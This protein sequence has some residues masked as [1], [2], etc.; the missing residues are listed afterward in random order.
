MLSIPEK[1][2]RAAKAYL[3]MGPE[4]IAHTELR[5]SGQRHSLLLYAAPPFFLGLFVEVRTAMKKLLLAAAGLT[6][7]AGLG[8]LWAPDHGCAQGP[9]GKAEAI[10]VP[11]GAGGTGPAVPANSA[12]A[13]QT[14]FESTAP[15]PDQK[16]L[17]TSPGLPA[18]PQPGH[19]AKDATEH[20]HSLREYLTQN[21]DDVDMNQD[22]AVQ[23]S[24]GEYMICLHWYSGAD[25]PRLARAMVSELRGPDYNLSAYVFT[26]GLEERQAEIKKIAEIV[27]KQKEQIAMLDPS[28][29][30]HI[31]VPLIRYEIQCAV[32]VGGYRDMKSAYSALEQLKKVSAKALQDKGLPLHREIVMKYDDK[33]KPAQGEYA[34]IDPFTHG[35]VVRNPSLPSARPTGTTAED[36]SLL[37]ALNENEPNSLLTCKGK[38]TLA[39]KQF[40]MPAML[41]KKGTSAV[42]T[43][44]NFTG[45]GDKP[46]SAAYNARHLAELLR[47][48]LVK[49]K[50]DA[51]VLHCK[52]SSYVTVGSFNRED[53]PQLLRLQQ[54]LPKHINTQLLSTLQLVARPVVMEVPH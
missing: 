36:Q 29:D 5:S 4:L 26:K 40:S 34:D 11:V 15:V 52:Y 27:Q 2:R 22:I 48:V 10:T 46:D 32:L 18:A 41:D 17:P 33:G 38:Y 25:A 19:A 21:V 23:P 44:M 39:V 43:N 6:A 12:P 20:P 8:V 14:L 50:V 51:Y 24:C 54:D 13:V 7:L 3:A 42:Q 47:K 1:P 28:A 37:R 45:S 9:G 16:Y 30:A 31:R 53:D 49:E 35:M